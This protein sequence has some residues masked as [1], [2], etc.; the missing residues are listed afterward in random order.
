[1]NITNIKEYINKHSRLISSI[2]LV[3]GFIFNAIVLKRV[4]LFWENFWVAIHIIICAICIVYLNFEKLPEKFKSEKLNIFSLIALQFTFGGLLSTFIVFYFRSAVLQVA[5]PFLLALL[6][7]F[8]INESF[9]H[10]YVRM[11][12]Q[13]LFLFLSV[14]LYLSYLVPLILNDVNS[15]IF[16]IS[17][18]VSTFIIIIFI[19]VISLTSPVRFKLEKRTVVS[20]VIG[21]LIMVNG[22][23]T[24]NII[25]PLPLSL[26]DAGIYHDLTYKNRNYVAL[27]EEKNIGDSIFELLGMYGTY[28]AT[29]NTTAYAYSSIFAPKKF[30]QEV[31]HDWQYF[32]QQDKNWE[33]RFSTKLN[34]TGG[35]DDGFRTYSNYNSLVPGKWRVNI[36]LDNGQVIGRIMF[37][38]STKTISN[39]ELKSIVL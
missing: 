7:A 18:A 27:S 28:N 19:K 2:T 34:I 25:P 5:W 1:M 38:V 8:L 26:Q 31:F 39:G 11:D 22:F 21:I 6:I 33:T 35:R 32:N 14:Y 15:K 36:R 29:N 20:S 10:K 24:L 3:S 30:A 16:F 23:Y 4:D 12:F 9:K 13:I 37:N 17:G